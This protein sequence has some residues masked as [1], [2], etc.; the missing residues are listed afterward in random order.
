MRALKTTPFDFDETAQLLTWAKTSSAIDAS[1]ASRILR[2]ILLNNSP[3]AF[4]KYLFIISRL[5]STLLDER[6]QIH[7]M[8]IGATKPF[9]AAS[10]ANFS[11]VFRNNASRIF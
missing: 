1:F 5:F 6:S 2:R 3:S 10:T 4:C 9:S 11:T 8:F 7:I